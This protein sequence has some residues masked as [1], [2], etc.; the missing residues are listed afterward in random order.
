MTKS[1]TTPSTNKSAR[2]P[3]GGQKLAPAGAP[4]V[5]A[6]APA[7]TT[8]DMEKKFAGLWRFNLIMGFLHLVQG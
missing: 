8:A 7:G 1:K 4:A 2:K 3:S 6:T 5:A